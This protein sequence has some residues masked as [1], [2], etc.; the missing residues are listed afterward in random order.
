MKQLAENGYVEFQTRNEAMGERIFTFTRGYVSITALDLVQKEMKRGGSIGLDVKTC[1]CTLR[2]THGLPCAHEI[3]QYKRES[4]PIPLPSIDSHWKKL[5]CEPTTSTN[6]N[7][8][9]MGEISMLIKRFENSNNELKLD[10]LK[11]LKEISNP[12]TTTLVEQQVKAGTR[13]RPK[14]ALA[15]RQ[16]EAEASTTTNPSSFEL[17]SMFSKRKSRMLNQQ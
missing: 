9:Y 5:S 15:R 6:S 17:T 2:Q 11:K 14:N 3:V 1:C 4:C 12:T 16:A 10:M 8:Y 7:A 13:G